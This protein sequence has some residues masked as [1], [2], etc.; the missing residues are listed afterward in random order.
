MLKKR[1]RNDFILLLSHCL[2]QA[3]ARGYLLR[4]EVRKAREDFEDI[5]TEIDGRLNHLQWRDAILS[6][7]RF[8]YTVCFRSDLCI[9]PT[10]FNLLNISNV[11]VLTPQDGLLP[12]KTSSKSAPTPKLHCQEAKHPPERL[13]DKTEGEPRQQ[14]FTEKIEAERDGLHFQK[15][16]ASPR[17]CSPAL[18]A[19]V[20]HSHSD[21][22]GSIGDS[23]TSTMWR[24]EEL[25][26]GFAPTQRGEMLTTLGG[27][28]LDCEWYPELSIIVQ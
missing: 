8:T 20:G 4:R 23:T 7:P 21:G 9:I 11:P 5:V 17:E 10:H 3:R 16:P 12:R 13:L 24:S 28:I 22:Q 1:P 14:L 6:S 25:D 2:P 26:T 19:D 15:Q 27:S 18:P